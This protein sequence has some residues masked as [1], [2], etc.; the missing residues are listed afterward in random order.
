MKE[1]R[2]YQ[3]YILTGLFFILAAILENQTLHN[4]PETKI[5]REFQ[6]TL[7]HQEFKLSKYL[8]QE[9]KKITQSLSSKEN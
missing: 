5:I 1:F 8:D 7:L 2:K 6:V 3:F 4:H 9:E